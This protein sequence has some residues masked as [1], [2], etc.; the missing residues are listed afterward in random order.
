[1]AA[2]LRRLGFEVTTELDTD[3]GELTEALR[4][5]TDSWQRGTPMPVTL[6]SACMTKMAPKWTVM[7]CRIVCRWW[8]SQRERSGRTGR[9]SQPT[10]YAVTVQHM[11]GMTICRLIY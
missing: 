7:S 2:A 1:M 3:R 10:M 11:G 6:T 5:F 8:N 9:C 4:D